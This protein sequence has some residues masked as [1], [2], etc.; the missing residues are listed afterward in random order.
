MLV[1]PIGLL[2][3]AGD[4]SGVDMRRTLSP[5]PHPRWS[6]WQTDSKRAALDLLILDGY[7][8]EKWSSPAFLEALDLGL[9]GPREELIVDPLGLSIQTC[10]RPADSRASGR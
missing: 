9:I 5:A 1:C 10:S 3:E 8:T 7:V 2:E 6:L 4:V